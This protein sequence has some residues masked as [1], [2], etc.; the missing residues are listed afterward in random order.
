MPCPQSYTRHMAQSLG[1]VYDPLHAESHVVAR[2]QWLLGAS[3]Q[4]GHFLL[5]QTHRQCLPVRFDTRLH[6]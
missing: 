2:A 3:R 6:E 5:T 1:H 4:M